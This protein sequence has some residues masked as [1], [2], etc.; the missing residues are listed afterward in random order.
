MQ[1]E[2]NTNKEKRSIKQSK[3]LK[4]KQFEINDVFVQTF[5]LLLMMKLNF[6]LLRNASRKKR[7]VRFCLFYFSILIMLK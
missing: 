4:R 5:F 2:V 7:K 1:I 3:S 6:S